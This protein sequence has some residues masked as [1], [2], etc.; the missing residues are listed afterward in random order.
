MITVIGTS[1]P[2]NSQWHSDENELIQ[3]ITTQIKNTFKDDLN[4]FINTTW[5]GPQFDNGEFSKF[6][7]TVNF[8]KYD[9]LFLLASVDPVFL[10][11][12]QIEKIFKIS[13]AKNLYLLGNFETD[14]C[15]T[16][17]STLLPKYFKK[18][19][20]DEIIMKNCK[21]LFV[22]YN[23]KPRKHRIELIEKMNQ[24]KLLDLGLY[25]LGK[26]HSLYSGSLH[27]NLQNTLGEAP[28]E[29]NWGM[30]VEEFGIAHDI[31][32]LG[33]LDIWQNHFINIISETEF[34]PWDNM[35]ITE[36]T[37]KPIL[38]LRPFIINGQ[39]QI[40]KYLKKEGFKVFNH[41]WPTI[42]LENSTDITVHEN[43]CEIIKFLTKFSKKELMSMYN[44]ML[45]DLYYNQTRF[46][47][48]AQEQKNKIENLFL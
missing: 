35:F 40:Y 1:F 41:Y 48:F 22:C 36:K 2:K 3:N 39:P 34:N 26:T 28:N 14:Y 9:N 31:H 47:E 45:P 38:G 16:F 17:I 5:F 27:S 20:N 13:G 23:R 25:T 44:D 32:T 12:D 46:Y 11:K 29:G 30:D 24:Y 19:S 8:Q 6:I 10:T 37:W 21:H 43:I 7:K 4:L 18:Y 42:D 15:F 33:S